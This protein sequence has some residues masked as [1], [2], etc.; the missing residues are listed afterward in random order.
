M[1]LG[2]Q[3]SSITEV[4]TA[5]PTMARVSRSLLRAICSNNKFKLRAGDVT[6]AFL[7]TSESLEDLGLTVWAPSELAV[8]LGGDPSHPVMPLRVCRAFYGLVRSPRCWFE[9]VSTKLQ[10]QEWQCIL[11][12]WCIFCLYDD[13]TK[14]IIAIAGLHVDDFLLGGQ[15][16]HPKFN[17]ALKTLQETYK[18]GKWQQDE[19]EF[20]GSHIV[21]LQD[22]PIQ[23]DQQSYVEKWLDEIE[24]PKEGASQ[25]KSPLNQRETLMLRGAI[26]SIAWKSVQ[27]GPHFQ[28]EAG[29][30][31]SE[32]PK[33]TVNTIIK[34]NKLI[35][36]IK[37]E[38]CQRLKFPCWGRRW[39]EMAIVTWCDA[40][41]KDRPD[42]SSTL[43]HITGIA[44]K[45]FLEGEECVVLF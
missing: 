41:Q 36:E 2:F 43:G 35:R 44:P 4:E 24:L 14:D 12:D 39:D 29:L 8:L 15:E 17:A 33:A 20:A 10:K 9:D 42:L 1:I 28:A 5:A 38:S 18:W 25:L 37:R 7:Q 11:A 6:S 31:L 27:T 45:E 34:T 19:F 30:L 40:G 21:Q 23:V 26:G 16:D 32:I 22:G 3:M 13:E